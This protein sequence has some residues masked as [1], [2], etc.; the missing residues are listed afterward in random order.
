MTDFLSGPGPV[1]EISQESGRSLPRLS[2]QRPALTPGARLTALTT[3]V[4]VVLTGG[5]VTAAW[6]AFEPHHGPESL[7]PS[8]AFAVGTIDLSMPGGQAD[9]LRSFAD[10]FPSSPTHHG[11][12]SAVDRLLRAIFRGSSDPHVDYDRDV[13]P[14]LGDHVALAGWTDKDGKPQMEALLESTDDGAAKAELSKLFRDG[15]G[16]VRFADGYAVIGADDAKVRETIEAAHRSSLA[17]NATYAGDID[18]LPGDPALT[19][20]M[21]GPAVRKAIESAMGPEGARMFSEM[22]PFGP[23]AMFGPM[24]LVAAGSGAPASGALGTASASFAGRSSLGVRVADRYLEVDMRSTGA[25]E[26][27]QVSTSQLRELPA[28]T[29]GALQIGD[30]ASLVNSATAMAKSFMS[31]PDALSVTSEGSCTITSVIP[32]IPPDSA[33]PLTQ[34]DKRKMLRRLRT[35]RRREI[36]RQ[37]LHQGQNA[38]PLCDETP[39]TPAEPVDPLKQI[40]SNTGLRLPDDATAVVGD[41]LLASYGGLSLGGLPKV[42][43]R[44]HPADL[45]AA[46][47]VIDKV[48]NHLGPASDVP[49]AV[50]TSGDDLIL[51]TSSDYAHDVEQSGSLGEQEQVGL[52]LGDLPDTVVSAGYV[53]LSMILPLLGGTPRDVQALEAVGF[54]T[55]LDHGSQD[56]QM[57]VVVG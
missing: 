52:A 2:R 37:R 30:P 42:A 57:R 28:T 49:L 24:G 32:A 50:D 38:T 55:A 6:R 15:D 9:A 41:S 45:S 17:D 27:H 29:I 22:G 33:A 53:D 44:T 23:L 10:H 39:S 21:D 8:T 51:A 1:D 18:A 48:Q 16:A 11:D 47:A 20:W 36:M 3:A 35:I 40:E 26:Q 5:V 12:G 56:S 43:V 14:W 4:A 46:Q 7:V 25:G 31:L 54:W 13:K 19:A 34:R